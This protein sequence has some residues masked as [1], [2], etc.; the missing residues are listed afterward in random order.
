MI[1]IALLTQGA[2]RA[3]A[4][5]TQEEVLAWHCQTLGVRFLQQPPLLG[6]HCQQAR[7]ALVP[8]PRNNAGSRDGAHPAKPPSLATRS[9]RRGQP[10][11][12]GRSL[13]A[14]VAQGRRLP[15]EPRPLDS[16]S[17]FMTPTCR[18]GRS[19]PW[20][21]RGSIPCRTYCTR[22]TASPCTAISMNITTT[23]SMTS[24]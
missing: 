17:Y 7:P 2:G 4:Q 15:F 20:A 24:P 18:M 9:G 22:A 3:S 19:G 5:V 13:S 23:S 16:A 14:Q 10:H 11:S 1:S 21:C 6:S 12:P 8:G